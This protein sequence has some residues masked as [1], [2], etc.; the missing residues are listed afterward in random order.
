[1][2]S[3]STRTASARFIPP[4]FH[5]VSSVMK[6]TT[7]HKHAMIG[8][9][10]G[11]IPRP[12]PSRS[13]VPTR[14]TAM[15]SVNPTT[16]NMHNP[17]LGIQNNATDLIGDTPMARSSH[18]PPSRESLNPWCLQVYLTKLTTG[19][20]AKIACKLE[21]VNPCRRY[22]HMRAPPCVHRTLTFCRSCAQR[23]G[24]NSPQHGQESRGGRLDLPRAH[25]PGTAPRQLP[26]VAPRAQVLGCLRSQVEPTSGNTGVGL[27]YVAAAKG[28]KLVLTMPDTMSLERRILLKALGAELILTRG[29]LVRAHH[30]VWIRTCR[31]QQFGRPQAAGA[32]FGASIAPT[33]TSPRDCVGLCTAFSCLVCGTMR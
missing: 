31:F 20:Y 14:C 4:R 17:R 8:N 16:T 21:M 30:V 11:R 13:M 27:A 9:T 10:T 28:Y 7:C 6:S 23:E 12:R 24:P 29:R 22:A 3:G 18:A 1:M 33:H 15:P 2:R 5:A 25:H 32:C 26:L 19:C